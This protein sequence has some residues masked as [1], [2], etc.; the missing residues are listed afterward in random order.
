MRNEADV[1]AWIHT[2]II[3]PIA[4]VVL[5]M[6]PQPRSYDILFLQELT[7]RCGEARVDMTISWRCTGGRG[8]LVLIEYKAPSVVGNSIKGTENRDWDLMTRQ[9]RKYAVLYKCRRVILMDEKVALLFCFQNAEDENSAVYRAD[10]V[11][12]GVTSFTVRELVTFAVW[13]AITER[14]GGVGLKNFEGIQQTEYSY[15]P[16]RPPPDQPT[17]RTNPQRSA[18]TDS[19]ATTGRVLHRV[20]CI[21]IPGDSKASWNM[22]G[23]NDSHQMVYNRTEEDEDSPDGYS[24]YNISWSG[25]VYYSPTSRDSDGAA[26]YP[27]IASPR[28]IH[29]SPPSS[30]SDCATNSSPP[31]SVFYGDT[32]H[33]RSSS[34]DPRMCPATDTPVETAKKYEPSIDLPNRVT[35]HRLTPSAVTEFL[36]QSAIH[37]QT[38]TQLQPYRRQLLATATLA[39]SREEITFILKPFLPDEHRRLIRELRAYGSLMSLQGHGIPFCGGVLR[40]PVPLR[41]YDDDETL[42]LALEFI[43]YP[44]LASAKRNLHPADIAALFPYAK[45]IV[46]SIHAQGVLQGDMNDRNILVSPGSDSPV[47]IID[48]DRAYLAEEDV[49]VDEESFDEE[50]KD[51]KW[52][53]TDGVDMEASSSFTDS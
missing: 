21:H 26:S 41:P 20:R 5:A 51:L 29:H 19:A 4:P 25:S 38:V 11:A 48:F 35:Y 40:A 36:S 10:A 49:C 39:G 44:T 28:A 42:Y 30:V 6:L 50:L 22:S 53:F 43:P 13:M 12:G 17:P 24:G 46:S 14:D 33:P 7:S 15:S 2:H 8:E 23:C 34:S 3:A 37:L 18:R 45:R 32:D 52:R 31:S 1:R 9:V 16:E 27:H 47:R